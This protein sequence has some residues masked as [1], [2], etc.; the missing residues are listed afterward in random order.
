MLVRIEPLRS[1]FIAAGFRGSIGATTILTRRDV[2]RIYPEGGFQFCWSPR[3]KD[4]HVWCDENGFLEKGPD[5][6]TN[7]LAGLDYHEDDLAEALASGSEIM[8]ACKRYVAILS[9]DRHST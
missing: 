1:S 4:L 5:A 2:Y 6:L 3:V 8:V 9:P 7:A